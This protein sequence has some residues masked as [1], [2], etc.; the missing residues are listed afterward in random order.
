M[1]L[2]RLDKDVNFLNEHTWIMGIM[3]ITPDSFS[4]GGKYFS[5]EGIRNQTQRMLDEQV[6]VI[7]VGGESTRPGHTPTTVTEE[8]ERVIPA[9]QLIREISQD[10]IISVDT[11]KADV[12]RAALQAGADIINDQWAATREPKIAKVCAEFNAPLILMHNREEYVPY[13]DVMAEMKVDLQKSIDIALEQGMER[14]QLLVDPGVGFVKSPD[15]NVE[16]IS[17]LS[18]LRDLGL[19]ILLATSRK[20]FIGTLLNEVSAD[21]RDIG[22]AATTTAGI[23]NGGADMVRVHNVK[24]NKEAALVADAIKEGKMTNV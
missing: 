11:W 8:L 16:A 18:E 12:A 13:K 4:D 2:P 15:E 6:D 23:L 21:R 9:I 3:N 1:Y 19:P 10:V 17:R 14:E 5:E 20:R 22:T 7:D 24:V